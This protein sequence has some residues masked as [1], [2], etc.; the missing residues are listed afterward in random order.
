VVAD[1]GTLSNW[2]ALRKHALL[3]QL[4]QRVRV[5]VNHNLWQNGSTMLRVTKRL[6]DI[7]QEGP[8]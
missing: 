1:C 3:I 5:S 7:N 8:K 6:C 2:A 4:Q